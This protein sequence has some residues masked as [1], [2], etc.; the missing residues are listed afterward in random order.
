MILRQDNPEGVAR[1]NPARGT[2]KPA[3]HVTR[4]GFT[5]LELLVV[6]GILG[7]LA[8]ITLPSLKTAQKSNALAAAS[9]QLVDDLGL[10]RRIA[11]KDRTTVV[12]VF[13]PAVNPAEAGSYSALNEGE[14]NVLLRG[15]QTAYAV[16]SFRQVGDQPG[17]AH[18]RFLRSWRYLP[19]GYMIPSWKFK[20]GTP[21]TSIV[22]TNS[23]E[24][25]SAILKVNP[26]PWT[27][28][29]VQAP[30]ARVPVPSL[31]SPRRVYVSLPY[32][33]FGP[34]GGL[35]VLDNNGQPEDALT[36]EYIPLA[37]GSIFLARDPIDEKTLV[38]EPADIRE[39]TLAA[40]LNDYHV[41]VIDRLTGRARVAKPEISP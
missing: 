6:I 30:T 40:F 19:G 35:Q 3:R 20:A 9:Q 36:D 34:T 28:A 8:A 27:P 10:A 37:R 23:R 16:Y 11:I 41:I 2:E 13:F 26:F 22:A 32:I 5:L 24:G 4:E 38:W 31:N 17:D 15:Q 1:L 33:A 21:P 7:I 18:P 12:M 29:A 39:P 25:P 14:R